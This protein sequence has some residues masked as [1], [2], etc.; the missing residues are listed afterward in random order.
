MNKAIPRANRPPK[1]RASEGLMA[2]AAPVLDD[3]AE[4]DVAEL[5]VEVPV[6]APVEVPLAPV[7]AV[8]PVVP[9][10]AVVPARLT[11]AL[12]ARAL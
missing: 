2:V 9:F 11:V 6:G 3:V 1:V 8:V 4:L 10:E 5:E 7:L 12:A